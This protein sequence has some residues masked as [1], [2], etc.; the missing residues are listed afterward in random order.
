[1]TTRTGRLLR[2]LDLLGGGT[3]WSAVHLSGLLEVPQRTLRRDIAELRDLGYRIEGVPGPGGH[4]HLE[5]G[6]GAPPQPFPL[7]D[8]AV[9]IDT[10]TP[11]VPDSLI[12]LLT[13]A[14]DEHREVTFNHNGRDG[15]RRRSVEPARVVHLDGRWYLH[16]WDRDRRDWRTFRLDRIVDL[17][18]TG[19]RFTPARL[20]REDVTALLREQFRGDATVEVVLELM[21]DPVTAAA[22]LHRVDGTLEATDGGRRTRYTAR[23][24]SFE[25]LTVVLVLTDIDFTVVSP[26]GFRETLGQIA[27]RFHRAC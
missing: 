20:P 5:P 12:T 16:G 17:S 22:A 26:P 14:V 1:M 25:W 15:T 11:G 2:L 9:E 8:R 23:V 4:Y 21:T 7:P 13:H 24:D 18:L 6:R 19:N 3:A 27:D 10:S